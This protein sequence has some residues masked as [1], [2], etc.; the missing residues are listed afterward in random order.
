MWETGNE[1]GEVG[2]AKAV[3]GGGKEQYLRATFSICLTADLRC[4]NSVLSRADPC[5]LSVSLKAFAS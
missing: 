2:T 1:E 3:S 4:F 5:V